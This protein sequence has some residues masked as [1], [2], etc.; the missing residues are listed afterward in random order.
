MTIK[1]YLK[2]KTVLLITHSLYF[3]PHSDR[4][5]MFDDGMIKYCGPYEE[6]KNSPELCKVEASKLKI[7]SDF[8]R[9]FN[10]HVE[11]A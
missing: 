3:V 2:G 4:V 10:N 5:L 1:E 7:R 9:I 11:F 8:D 6:A